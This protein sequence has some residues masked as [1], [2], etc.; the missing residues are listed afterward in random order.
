MLQP[1]HAHALSLLHPCFGPRRAALAQE[2]RQAEAA[3]GRLWRLQG[4][5]LADDGL[6]ALHFLA[7]GEG[8]RLAHATNG[9][10]A[11]AFGGRGD[12]VVEAIYK[13]RIT[14]PLLFAP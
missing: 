11:A 4:Y 10:Y 3:A 5:R 6:A 7:L 8:G 13:R 14:Q 9:A 2:R 1:N 12:G